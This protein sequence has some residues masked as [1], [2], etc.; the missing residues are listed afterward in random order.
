MLL[1]G[2]RARGWPPQIV[3]GLAVT[4]EGI[5]VRVWCWPGNTN[6]QTIL[7]EVRDGLR[8]WRLGRVVT[9]VGR[10]FS[11]DANLAYLQRGRRP[12]DRRGTHA[13][14]LG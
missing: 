5:P 6:D 7:P 8:G 2:L 10:G 14:R 3:I 13:G 1:V 4:R 12:L 11:S 9:V